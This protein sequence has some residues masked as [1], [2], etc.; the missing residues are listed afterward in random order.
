[1]KS[2]ILRFLFTEIVILKRSFILTRR[3]TIL[4]KKIAI[5]QSS[6]IPWKGYFDIINSVDEFVIYDTAGYSK[7]G[8]RNRNR[9][10]GPNGTRWLTIPVRVTRHNQPINEVRIHDFRWPA[11]HWK[12]LVANYGGS[13]FFRSYAQALE[14]LYESLAE[15][16]YLTT[17]NIAFLR[18]TSRLLGISTPFSMAEDLNDIQDPTE[19]LIRLCQIRGATSYV[20]GPSAS[21]YLRP[22]RFEEENIRVEW[23]NYDNY[24]E[25][26]QRGVPFNH[27]VSI[28]D[29]IFWTG[30]EATK[31]MKSFSHA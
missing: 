8:W 2:K 20:T 22:R 31:Y 23:M 4:S 21:D 9:I 29:L 28:L 30:P 11:K 1:M 24:P 3:F 18:F 10:T 14:R 25:Y 17:I 12:S 5:L 6:Y 13:P 7:N 15:E 26:P 27:A 16:P 19:K